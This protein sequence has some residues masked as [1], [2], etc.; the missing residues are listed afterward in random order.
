MEHA[1]RHTLVADALALQLKLPAAG[2]VSCSRTL[3]VVQ[4]RQ[5]QAIAVSLWSARTAF[6][7]CRCMLHRFTAAVI[8]PEARAHPVVVAVHMQDAGHNS[9][10][11][12]GSGV[13]HA[14]GGDAGIHLPVGRHHSQNPCPGA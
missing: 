3:P 11:I 1:L 6:R 7:V 5:F 10:L 12:R 9:A 4:P 13:W 8:V 14:C 2:W